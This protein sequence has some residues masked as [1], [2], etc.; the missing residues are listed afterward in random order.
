VFGVLVF[1]AW[2]LVAT[3]RGMLRTIRPFFLGTK[4]VGIL[5]LFGSQSGNLQKVDSRCPT[6]SLVQ[7]P[8][9]LP[10]RPKRRLRIQGFSQ[11]FQKLGSVPGRPNE[12]SV[13]LA[14]CHGLPPIISTQQNSNGCNADRIQSSDCCTVPADVMP[15]P[16]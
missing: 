9:S 16:A 12:A 15:F 10:F 13:G 8:D 3:Y 1:G 5:N 2:S 14:Q 7:V 6:S 11:S 4:S